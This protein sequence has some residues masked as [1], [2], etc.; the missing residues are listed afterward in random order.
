MYKKRKN[1]KSLFNKIKKKGNWHFDPSKKSK[2]AK[3]LGRIKLS[4]D[5]VSGAIKSVEKSPLVPAV[6]LY[7][8][9]LINKAYEKTPVAWGKV[10][11]IQAG[12]NAS[13]TLFKQK[14]FYQ[15]KTMPKW[16]KKMLTISKLRDAYLTVHMNPPGSTNP[17]H[18]DTY[19][20]IVKK[21]LNPRNNFKTVKR[22][23]IFIEPWH[24]GHF[25][26]VGNNIISNW[27]QGDVYTW[28]AKRYH[29][30]GNSGWTKRYILAIT[31]FAERLPKFKI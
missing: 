10:D 6:Q 19:E 4:S 26:Q 23:L 7:K 12:Y 1:N 8:K 24:W 17:W 18:Y 25:L 16:C 3:Y 30:A 21:N 13:N 5:I 9:D 2:D 31:G 11:N 28:D 22:I 20:G 15:D 27:K 14:Y 29:L